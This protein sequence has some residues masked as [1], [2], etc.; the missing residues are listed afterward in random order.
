MNSSKINDIGCKQK[1]KASCAIK[2][3]LKLK[4]Q[5][6][7]SSDYFIDIGST[8]V[9]GFEK[10]K[11]LFK[12]FDGGVISWDDTKKSWVKKRQGYDQHWCLPDQ[13]LPLGLNL[14]THCNQNGSSNSLTGKIA[15]QMNLNA[16]NETEFG[17][18][19]GTCRHFLDRCNQVYD[20]FNGE[21]EENCTMIS[22]PKGY[23]NESP[24]ARNKNNLDLK[25]DI[26]LVNL[27]D[28]KISRSTM[29]M[30]FFID[31]MW[32]DERLR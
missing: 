27:F 15:L 22:T 24:L 21:D 25:I 16:C 5:T 9:F 30:Q 32:K 7:F 31:L 13:I 10:G 11:V 12:S 3:K 14:W 26:K 18:N 17:C 28:L 1:A 29:K 2:E 4:I 19:D 20:C 23:N 8:Y 6:T